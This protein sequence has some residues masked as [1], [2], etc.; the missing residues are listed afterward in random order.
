MGIEYGGSEV[1]VKL[2]VQHPLGVK[3]GLSTRSYLSPCLVQARLRISLTGTLLFGAHS[4]VMD[5]NI[6]SFCFVVFWGFELRYVCLN[7]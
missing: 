1:G 2:G 4:R 5:T 6:Y 3:L 7:H